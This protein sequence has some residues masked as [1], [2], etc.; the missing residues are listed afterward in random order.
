EGMFVTN[1]IFSSEAQTYAEHNQISLYDGEKLKN[2]FYRMSI[3][4]LDSAQD[5]ILDFSLP[6]S[7][8][9]NEATRLNLVNPTSANISRATIIL[10]PFYVFNY[11]VDV[12]KLLRSPFHTEGTII[13]DALTG[14]ILSETA[15][16]DKKKNQAAYSFFSKSNTHPKDY[17]ELLNYMEK[18]QII[19]D[20]QI[21][22]P[23]FKYKIQNTG[24][25]VIIKHES[26]I[27]IDAA[28]RIV[29]EEL[30]EDKMKFLFLDLKS[31]HKDYFY[32]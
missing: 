32:F 19:Q 30:V 29:K 4:R 2:E 11:I 23:H 12:K 1:T 10:S 27:P 15:D 28:R 16:I 5:I 25:Y 22:K 17:E 14:E 8:G 26:K 31:S 20:L 21:I 24:D 18:S 6:V 13:L 7:V 9:Y 3:G